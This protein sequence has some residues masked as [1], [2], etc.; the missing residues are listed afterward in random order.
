MTENSPKLIF[1]INP[2]NSDNTEQENCQKKIPRPIIF[3]L[4]K[5]KEKEKLEGSQSLVIGDT[6]PMEEKEKN[7]I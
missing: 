4:K 5:I 1:D 7:Y 6:L 3:K 2:E